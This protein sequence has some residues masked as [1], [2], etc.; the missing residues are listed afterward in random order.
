MTFAFSENKSKKEV[1]DNTQVYSKDEADNRFFKRANIVVSTEEA[2]ATGT[3]NTI[4][5]Q[6]VD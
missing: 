5:I 6:I 1:Y 4:Y 3:P 2:P